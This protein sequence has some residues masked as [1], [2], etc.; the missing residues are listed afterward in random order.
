MKIRIPAAV[1]LAVLAAAVLAAQQPAPQ[2]PAP[3]QAQ[4]PPPVTFRVEIN[5]VEVDALVTDAQGNPVMDLTAADFEILEDGRPQAVTAFSLV[6]LPIE[7]AE[8]PLFAAGPIEPDVQTNTS[9][10]GRIYLIVLDDLHTT[11]SNTPRVKRALREFFDRN[12]GVNDLAAVVYTSGRGSDA[13]DFTNNRRLLLASV[14]KFLGRKLRSEVLETIDALNRPRDPSLGRPGD[15]L[16][17]ERGFNARTTMGSIRKLADFMGG[18]R[19]RRKAMLLVSEGISYNIYDV[20]TNSS[21]SLVMQ[22]TADAVAAAT[23]ANVAIYP[24]D[25][26]GLSAFDEAVEISASPAD[27]PGFSAA[28]GFQDALRLSQESLRVLA[29]ETGGFAAVNRN[30]FGDAFARMVR[31]NSSYYV[32]GYYSTNERRDGRYRRL[33][34]RVKR[35]GLQVR[36]RRGYVAPRG[37]APEA[38]AATPAANPLTV[39]VNDALGSPIPISGIPLNVFAA[40]YKGT[41]PNAVVVLAVE[42]DGNEFRF[43]DTNGIFN[44][45]IELTFTSVDASGDVHPG[46]RHALTM[47]MRPETVALVRERGFRVISSTELPPGRYQLRMAAAEEGGGLTGSVLYDLEVPDF[48]KPAFSMSGL[49]MTSMLAALTPTVL[50]KD[51]L[52][53]FLPAPPTTAREFLQE[54]EVALFAEFYENTPGAPPHQLDLSTTMRAEDGRVVFQDRDERSSTDLQGG[55][56]GHGYQVRIPLRG[57]APGTYVIRVEGRS[58]AGSDAGAGRDVVIRVR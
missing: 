28:R 16:E 42:M 57:F 23:R 21:A 18:V 10:E 6:N 1:V 47:T 49:S 40:A 36:S 17:A 41:A 52:A 32:L 13:Q 9:A 45:R 50:P 7:R 37:R 46:A 24:V 27:D 5:Y 26:R 3:P 20:I 14:D 15:P 53:D 31:E 51:P 54:D 44:D 25:P 4:E 56:G 48:Y 35:P 29:A 30:D 55:S 2:Q 34:V 8:R 39:A 12:F 33:E 19:G 58:R 38:R 11:F 22:E 43:A